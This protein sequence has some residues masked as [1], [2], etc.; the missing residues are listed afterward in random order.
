MNGHLF[1]LISHR[2]QEDAFITRQNI[3]I[4]HEIQLSSVIAGKPFRDIPDLPLSTRACGPISGKW[5]THF[6]SHAEAFID[7]S[8]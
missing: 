8:T 6:V 5:D 4:C 7:A 2:A 1:K 3:F